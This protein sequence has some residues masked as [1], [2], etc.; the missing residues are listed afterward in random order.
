MAD[1]LKTVSN[2]LGTLVFRETAANATI[3]ANVFN[4]TAP[5]MFVV[6]LDNSANSTEA[7]YLKL[8]EST[9]ADG[10][11][12]SVGTTVPSFVLKA[13]AS[14]SVEMLIPGG[15]QFATSNYAHL[16]VTATAGTAG[17]T[18]PTGTVSVTLIGT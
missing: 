6:K 1:I 5:Q 17:T 10:G 12:I 18:A 4:K 2:P 15:V 3:V 14:R 9:N 11:Q 16:A 13:P 8:Y 7:V